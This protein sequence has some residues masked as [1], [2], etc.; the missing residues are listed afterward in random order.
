VKSHN[1]IALS[2]P[3]ST[4]VGAAREA[5]TKLP[6]FVPTSG[7]ELTST[8]GN[9]HVPLITHADGRRITKTEAKEDFGFRALEVWTDPAMYECARMEKKLQEI[10]DAE[11]LGTRRLWRNA[12]HGDNFIKVVGTKSRP[13]MVYLTWSETAKGFI[14]DGT[15]IVGDPE[16]TKAHDEASGRMWGK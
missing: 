7:L 13:C 14:E 10:F 16:K 4:H 11:P 9:R 15:L 3:S 2:L 8:N 6:L 1:V 12:G 5:S